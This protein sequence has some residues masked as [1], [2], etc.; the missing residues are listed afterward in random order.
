M[1]NQSGLSIWALLIVC[2]LI[3]FFALLA[4]KLTPLYVDNLKLRDGLKVLSEN[5]T[6]HTMTRNQMV[7]KLREKL[8][9]DSAHNI[10]DVKSVFHVEKT[11]T[12]II[13][14]LDYERV[15]HL[16]FNISALLDFENS[17]TTPLP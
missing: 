6:F 17:V 14:S 10:V 15:E 1:R 16:A 2:S 4:M 11:K 3:V 7:A 5:P 13:I 8:Y 9:V 12:D